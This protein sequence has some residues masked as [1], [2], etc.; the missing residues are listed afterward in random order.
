MASG[1]VSSGEQ[2]RPLYALGWHDA[3]S[4]FVRLQTIIQPFGTK[5]YL[6]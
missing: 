2:T 5:P 4:M 6:S 1:L 3:Q